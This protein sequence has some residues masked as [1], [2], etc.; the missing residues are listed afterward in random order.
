M[1]FLLRL[2][3]IKRE[4][5]WLL[6]VESFYV[7]LLL[8]IRLTVNVL[9]V[10]LCQLHLL[11]VILIKFHLLFKRLVIS[12]KLFQFFSFDPCL[13]GLFLL[14][15][16]FDLLLLGQ[17]FPE[18]LLLDLVFEN[19]PVPKLLMRILSPY[20]PARSLSIVDDL[21]VDLHNVGLVGGRC[22]GIG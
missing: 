8:I 9:I 1:I 3:R 18:L 6:L 20:V 15:I 11:S 22:I 5:S 7:V 4:A 16:K 17:L 14:H 19:A 10:Y 21:A 12:L 13:F 2:T